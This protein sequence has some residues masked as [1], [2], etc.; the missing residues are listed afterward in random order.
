MN[1][2]VLTGRRTPI[3]A[4][5][6]WQT[7]L[8]L[9]PSSL[10]QLP[11]KYVPFLA[12]GDL[13]GMPHSMS[14]ILYPPGMRASMLDTLNQP[15]NYGLDSPVIE[16]YW[17]E[18]FSR[19]WSD[20]R[21]WSELSLSRQGQLGALL[22]CLSEQR[23]LVGL[24][25]DLQS[26][27]ISNVEGC[28][29]LYEGARAII[30]L[31]PTNASARAMLDALGRHAGDPTIRAL[32]VIHLSA[33]QS[34]VDREQQ[35]A[36]ETLSNGVAAV[37]HCDDSTLEGVVVRSRW[38]RVQALIDSK[39]RRFS[40][41]S[42]NLR[43]ARAYA[44]HAV[45]LASSRAPY[46][47]LV[48]AENLKMVLEATILGAAGAGNAGLVASVAFELL[49]LDP[50]DS[51]TWRTVGTAATRTNLVLSATTAL[52]GVTMLGGT[53]VSQ[54]ADELDHQSI[55]VLHNADF[56]L[57]ELLRHMLVGTY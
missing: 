45:D 17:S 18:E 49:R 28:A 53:G 26:D 32:S 13:G 41:A 8:T 40:A 20:L 1:A 16:S 2:H 25:A 22:N 7:F 48:A 34:R 51:Y 54:M 12:V 19:V 35:A 23:L 52:A 4:R 14:A 11:A 30:R 37:E 39:Q 46:M 57:S 56:E 6:Y 42:D 44:D 47:Q 33:M 31:S 38:A 24:V 36:S 29:V 21:Q 27:L 50:Y 10:S 9:A 3:V 15:V 5:A 55:Q 43:Q